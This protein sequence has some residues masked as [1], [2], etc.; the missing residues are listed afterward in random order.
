MHDNELIHNY[1]IYN[2]VPHAVPRDGRSEIT[3]PFKS[4]TLKEYTIEAVVERA[5]RQ[6]S[7]GLLAERNRTH[8]QQAMIRMRKESINH[9]ENLCKKH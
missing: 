8:L 3:S 4:R 9:S 7:L 5:M 1:I 2:Y 6:I